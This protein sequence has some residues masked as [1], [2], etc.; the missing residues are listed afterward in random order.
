MK[1]FINRILKVLYMIRH[2]ED[3]YNYY[4]IFIMP[5]QQVGFSKRLYVLRQRII[6]VST[7]KDYDVKLLNIC[8]S[9][10]RN[11]VAVTVFLLL[12]L[13]SYSFNRS[14]IY[15]GRPTFDFIHHKPV[16]TVN[17]VCKKV[18][19]TAYH[20]GRRVDIKCGRSS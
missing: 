10:Y 14:M 5:Y 20:R 13:S 12:C 7:A 11:V 1:K 3:K 18:V 2:Y 4:I 16:R 8:E 17:R 15:G 6:I 19:L 9:N